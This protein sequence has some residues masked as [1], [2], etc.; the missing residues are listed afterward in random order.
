MKMVGLKVEEA[1]EEKRRIRGELDTTVFDF[2]QEET[3][4]D[5]RRQPDEMLTRLDRDIPLQV[6]LF[7][8]FY[9]STFNVRSG[10]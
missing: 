7:F 6:L 4:L 5:A 9:S 2:L 8:S 1:R 10:S 3:G